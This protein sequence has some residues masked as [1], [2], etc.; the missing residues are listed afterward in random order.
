MPQTAA[1]VALTDGTVLNLTAGRRAGCR[2]WRSVRIVL[3]CADGATNEQVAADLRV[4]PATLSKWRQRFAARR[5]DGLTDEQR[6]GRPP[7]ILLDQVKQPRG[8]PQQL[9]FAGPATPEP[10][11]AGR[12]LQ[13]PRHRLVRAHG[14]PRPVQRPLGRAGRGIGR[15]G[16]SS[17]CPPAGV[18][19]Q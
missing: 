3:A 2:G 17:M 14:G 6:P 19:P 8:V 9:E 5:C 11:P 16:E 12:R 1:P 7:S 13:V 15:I 18:A 4:D 10:G